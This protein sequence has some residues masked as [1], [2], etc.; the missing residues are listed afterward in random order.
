M[1]NDLPERSA[2]VK[3]AGD[4]VDLENAEEE[5]IAARAMERDTAAA[6]TVVELAA[7]AKVAAAAAAT[8]A[9]EHFQRTGEE[10]EL[11]DV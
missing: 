7:T 3:R 11:D 10:V 2:A 1:I 4:V 8:A 5:S 9:A 6:A